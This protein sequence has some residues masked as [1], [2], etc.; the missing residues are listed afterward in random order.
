MAKKATRSSPLSGRVDRLEGRVDR[1]EHRVDGLEGPSAV[2]AEGPPPPPQKKGPRCPGCRL[3]IGS[4]RAR[5]CEW[6]GFVLSEGR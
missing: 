6:C 1:L 4:A 5:Q 3:E 2:K